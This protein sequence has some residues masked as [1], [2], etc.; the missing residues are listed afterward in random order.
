MHVSELKTKTSTLWNTMFPKLFPLNNNSNHDTSTSSTKLGKQ[1]KPNQHRPCHPPDTPTPFPDHLPNI[2][3]LSPSRRS[4]S[5]LP[6]PIRV[7]IPVNRPEILIRRPIHSFILIF[8][9]RKP[10]IEVPGLG[11]ERCRARGV[12]GGK[13]VAVANS[14]T[15]AS[16]A[17]GRGA[18]VEIVMVGG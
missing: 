14:W 1:G 17:C 18:D 9:L 5:N 10:G 16:G 12:F 4:I 7:S 13:T 3:F 8:T 2:A 6:A 15:Y 11:D